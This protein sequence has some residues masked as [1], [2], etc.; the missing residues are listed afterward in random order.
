MTKEMCEL[1]WG[2]PTEIVKK[3]TSAEEWIY[4]NATV[5]FNKNVVTA[6]SYNRTS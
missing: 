4:P 5:E 6:M 2:K 3:S 1:A